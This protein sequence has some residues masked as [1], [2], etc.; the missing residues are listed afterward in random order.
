MMLTKCK[1][2]S[3]VSLYDDNNNNNNNETESDFFSYDELRVHLNTVNTS[4]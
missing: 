2:M 3:V 4:V 1:I